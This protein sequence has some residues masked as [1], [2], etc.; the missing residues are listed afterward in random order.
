[1]KTPGNFGKEVE[2]DSG[3]VEELNWRT[4]HGHRS[5][6]ERCNSW[7]SGQ[8]EHEEKALPSHQ[9]IW[10]QPYDHSGKVTKDIGA[11]FETLLNPVPACTRVC[12]MCV[13]YVCSVPRLFWNLACHWGWAVWQTDCNTPFPL[14]G[15]G[16][17]IQNETEGPRE[18]VLQDGEMQGV[19][20]YMAFWKCGQCLNMQILNKSETTD[21]LK[22]LC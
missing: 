17:W 16:L 19:L 11:A 5:K 1:M 22:S 3:G 4:V 2:K 8:R 15:Q 10:T 12:E 20:K 21:Y 18:E 6:L 13:R 14:R 7:E 9:G